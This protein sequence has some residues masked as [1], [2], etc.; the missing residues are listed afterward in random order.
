MYYTMHTRNTLRLLTVQGFGINIGHMRLD[1][2][3]FQVEK[4]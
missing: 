4:R 3:D 1:R 2:R